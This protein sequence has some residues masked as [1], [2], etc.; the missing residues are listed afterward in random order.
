MRPLFLFPIIAVCTATNL[1]HA[2]QQAETPKLTLSPEANARIKELTSKGKPIDSAK[3]DV[4]R[5][6]V[7]SGKPLPDIGYFAEYCVARPG[8]KGIAPAQE[9]Y[10]PKDLK[11]QDH[12]LTYEQSPLLKGLGG[13]T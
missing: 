3:C 6:I 10:I 7:S 4:L 1:T 9:T 5:S 2:Q 12:W 8:E 13:D 11:E